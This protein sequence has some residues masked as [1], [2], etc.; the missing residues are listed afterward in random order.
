MYDD[1]YNS[2]VKAGVATATPEERMYN[3]SGILVFNKDTNFSCPTKYKLTIPGNVIFV[4]ETGFCTALY[5]MGTLDP[6]G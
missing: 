6:Y 1:I 5:T 2:M 4:D 3:Q